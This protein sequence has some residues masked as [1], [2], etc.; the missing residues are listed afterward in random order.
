[1]KNI[2]SLVT[3]YLAFFLVIGCDENSDVITI[4]EDTV[5]PSIEIINSLMTRSLSN[6]DTISSDVYILGCYEIEYP[7]SFVNVDGTT[8]QIN[9]ETQLE[10][11]FSSN[12]ANSIIDFVY[13]INLKSEVLGNIDVNNI[14]EL[15]EAFASCF[16]VYHTD[17]LPAYL[18][19]FDNSCYE[20]QFPVS[21]KKVDNSIV[22]IADEES[23]NIA[24][25]QDLHFFNYP[26]TLKHETGS[27]IIVQDENEL[28]ETLAN[29]STVE[30]I[31]S[32]DWGG[33]VFGCLHLNYPLEV[34]LLSGQTAVVNNENEFTSYLCTGQLGDF[35]F[36]LSLTKEDGTVVVAND[37]GEL[38]RLIDEC[39][40]GGGNGGQDL[41]ILLSGTPLDSLSACYNIQFPISATKTSEIG[42]SSIIEFN[43]YP[44]ILNEVF[45]GE[46][47]NLYTLQYPITVIL[48]VGNETKVIN[49]FEELIQLLSDCQ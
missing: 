28:F 2:F 18:I 7:F 47:G 48:I 36:P 30:I 15:T 3:I 37:D 34:I 12:E 9:S 29:C 23:F 31:D 35:K 25:A 32:L 6:N 33:S 4:E 21:L 16:P 49:N 14:E 40:G 8:I 5:T 44:D 11:I 45:N 38:S 22:Q 20:L 46:L 1:M 43:S 27:V 19:N 42:V 17:G 13:P 26:L 41:I 39:F 10:E 24:V